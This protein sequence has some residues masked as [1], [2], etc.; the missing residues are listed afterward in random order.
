MDVPTCIKFYYRHRPMILLFCNRSNNTCPHIW[1]DN[2]NVTYFNDKPEINSLSFSNHIRIK[3][4]CPH[5]ITYESVYCLPWCIDPYTG[6]PPDVG[7][8]KGVFVTEKIT[9]NHEYPIEGAKNGD[10]TKFCKPVQCRCVWK[11]D[12]RRN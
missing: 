6:N 9:V 7:N 4:M 11:P 5:N 3:V 1:E 2:C 10:T 12:D 8:A